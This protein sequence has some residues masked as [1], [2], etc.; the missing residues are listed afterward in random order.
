MTERRAMRVNAEAR[1]ASAEQRR[2]RTRERLLDA[3]EAMVAERGV[4]AASIEEIVRAAGVSRGTFYNYFPTTTDLLHALNTRAAAHLDQRL[5]E[6]ARRAGDPVERLASALHAALAVHL[7][8]PV[9][10]WVALQIA[11]SRAPRQHSLEARFTA[12][13]EEGVRA[14]QLRQVEMSAAWT[15]AFGTLRMA[16]RDLVA[17]AASA[18]PPVEVIALVLAAFGVSYAEARRISREAAA[19]ALRR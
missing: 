12:I 9:R 4:E 7:S 18:G 8:D 14:G 6:I 16:Q 17:G 5:E 10:G 11:A 3:A 1:A 13:Y 15:V 2:A 19:A